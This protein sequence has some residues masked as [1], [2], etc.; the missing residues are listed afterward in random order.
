MNNI[1]FRVFMSIQRLPREVIDSF[2]EVSTP[3]L[4]DCMNRFYAMNPSVRNYGK[5]GIKLVGSALT[6]KAAPGDNIMIHKAID[7]A[8]EGDVIVIATGGDICH[9]MLGEIMC[10]LA[11]RKGVRGFVLDGAIRDVYAI[12][13]MGFPVFAAGST[14]GG[15]YKNGPGEINVPVCCGGVVVNPGDV[16]VGDDDGIV[17]VPRGEAKEVLKQAT[18][19]AAKE[20]QMIEDIARDCVDRS[21]VDKLLKERGCAIV[22]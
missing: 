5:P 8:E 20:R 19:L 12:R 14:P 2:K 21:W 9:S 17:V 13:E 10:R 16:I 7:I 18:A 1:G 4:A 22:E 3:N 11:A 6:V 15:P